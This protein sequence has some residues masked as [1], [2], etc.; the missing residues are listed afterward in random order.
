MIMLFSHSNCQ[1]VPLTTSAAT[2]EIVRKDSTSTPTQVD[3]SDGNTTHLPP[4]PTNSSLTAGSLSNTNDRVVPVSSEMESRGDHTNNIKLPALRGN[5]SLVAIAQHSNRDEEAG[6]VAELGSSQSQ[7]ALTKPQHFTR[8]EATAGLASHEATAKLQGSSSHESALKPSRGRNP[9]PTR[10]SSSN[11]QLSSSPKYPPAD[12]TVMRKSA[13]PVKLQS[14]M[15]VTRHST[16]KDTPLGYKPAAVRNQRVNTIGDHTNSRNY[17][18]D[19]DTRGTTIK[20]TDSV[21]PEANREQHG[22]LTDAQTKN[23]NSTEQLNVVDNAQDG[24]TISSSH[25]PGLDEHL[26]QQAQ[27]YDKL[28]Q[29]LILLQ[30]AKD[31]QTRDSSEERSEPPGTP[32]KISELKS[33]IKTALDEAVRLRADTEALQQRIITTVTVSLPAYMY[34][35]M[36][37]IDMN[38]Q[39]IC[40]ALVQF[41]CYQHRYEWKPEGI[42]FWLDM[43]ECEGAS[44]YYYYM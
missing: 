43:N 2:G 10:N 38:G 23:S 32:V 6:A 25:S 34:M 44:I 20:F 4:V 30:Q 35:Y 16:F 14:Q 31:G 8:N 12:N 29:V 22:L 7:E 18:V 3:A 17:T 24:S 11:D 21:L 19:Q 36:Y 41:D 37:I 39:R 26:Y 27:R 13:S 15:R 9:R 28:N 40:G 33:H 1:Q 42:C 5:G